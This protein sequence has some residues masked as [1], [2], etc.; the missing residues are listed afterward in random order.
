MW[1]ACE[2]ENTYIILVSKPKDIRPLGRPK[3]R[4]E[5]KTEI[6]FKETVWPGISWIKIKSSSRVLL[7]W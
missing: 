3:H 1:H 6:D 2:D 5:A 7:T 4:D